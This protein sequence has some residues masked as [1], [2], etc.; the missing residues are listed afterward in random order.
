MVLRNAFEV[1]LSSD[2]AKYIFGESN[3]NFILSLDKNPD[4]R[5]RLLNKIV[6]EK[7]NI[8]SHF[9]SWV[10]NPYYQTQI[11]KI[12]SIALKIRL[13]I[14]ARILMPNKCSNSYYPNFELDYIYKQLRRNPNAPI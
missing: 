11:E 9:V 13:D 2:Q 6:N 7:M 8:P 5:A 10:T 14:R 4:E 1:T 12:T 3:Y